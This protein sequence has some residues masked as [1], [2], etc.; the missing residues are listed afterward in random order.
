MTPENPFYRRIRSFALRR[1]RT[2]LLQTR[3]LE[4]LSPHYCL[5]PGALVPE[6]IFGR[7]A[8]LVLEIGFGMG[9][10]LWQMA[11]QHPE[12]DFLGV[13]VHVPGIGALLDKVHAAS[14]SNVRVAQGDAN[15]VLATLPVA[16]LARVHIF[17][18]DPWQKKRHHKRRLIQNEFVSKIAEKMPL[19]GILHMATDWADY[20]EHMQAVMSERDDFIP[21]ASIPRPETK[22]ERRGKDLGHK[23]VDLSYQKISA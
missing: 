6:V 1:G 19:K 3:A 13:E 20:A 2:S 16:S 11:Q 9:G 10:A 4:E 5:K 18:P 17:F 23:I 7:K 15:D 14:L 21:C 22:F 8:P 12:W